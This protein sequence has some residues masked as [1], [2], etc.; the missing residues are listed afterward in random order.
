MDTQV[1]AWALR[2]AWEQHHMWDGISVV[3]DPASVPVADPPVPQGPE[4]WGQ[5]KKNPNAT[6]ARCRHL[7]L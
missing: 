1:E 2:R 3:T 4:L 7:P 5:R 6:P